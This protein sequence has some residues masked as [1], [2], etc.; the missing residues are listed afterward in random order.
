MQIFG[1]RGSRATHPE[2]TLAAF[3]HAI[4][5]GADGVE[6]DVWPRGEDQLVVTH[7]WTDAS[8]PT[9]DEVLALEAPDSFWFDIEAKSAPGLVPDADRY[10]DALSDN[11]QQFRR[12]MIVRSFD[13]AILR[14]FHAI[15]PDV[16]LAAL[17]D[18]DSNEWV[19]IALAAG[20]SI[21]SPHY[22]S[23]T[24]QRVRSAHDAGLQVSVWTVNDPADWDRMAA[25]GVD[26]VITDDPCA[27]VTHLKS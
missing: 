21:I 6:L 14:A 13:H 10:A 26:T 1:H 4:E 17:I 23:V 22:S 16:P 20:A 27:A 3:Q 19:F 7:D 9:L 11:L 8:L 2:N 15:E 12:R 25:L 18:Y 5:C 24:A